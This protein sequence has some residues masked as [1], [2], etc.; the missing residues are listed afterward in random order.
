LDAAGL[1]AIAGYRDLI[2]N[3]TTM[4]MHPWQDQD[5]LAEY[6]FTG[7]EIVYDI[8][9]NPRETLL[10]KRALRAGCRVIYGDAMLMAQACRQFLLYTGREYPASAPE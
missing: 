4:G 6:E 7:R 9:Y 1:A 8:V 5:P 10:L 3:T 2:V